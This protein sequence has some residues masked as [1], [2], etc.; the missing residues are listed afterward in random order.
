M[1]VGLV[2]FTERMILVSSLRQC[3]KQSQPATFLLLPAVRVSRKPKLTRRPVVTMTRQ[4]TKNRANSPQKLIM[5]M[6][7]VSEE[8][9]SQLNLLLLWG[10]D[11]EGFSVKLF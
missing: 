4:L 8:A 5:A 11:T 10:Y 3:P 7:T 2:Y 1:F 6:C 9:G